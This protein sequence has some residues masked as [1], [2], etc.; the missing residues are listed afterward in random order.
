MILGNHPGQTKENLRFAFRSSHLTCSTPPHHLPLP[1]TSASASSSGSATM[2]GDG[3]GSNGGRKRP[4]E[5]DGAGGGG[6]NA[7]GDGNDEGGAGGRDGPRAGASAGGGRG[8]E[9]DPDR[10]AKRRQ[11]RGAAWGLREVLSE[12]GVAEFASP[13]RRND[14]DG[15]SIATGGRGARS[16]GTTEASV[17]PRKRRKM[18]GRD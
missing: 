12:C 8:A 13:R 4:L 6:G 10:D 18:R 17:G 15:E 1:L 2:G 11:I 7:G 5:R 9:R 14:G 3:D 16:A